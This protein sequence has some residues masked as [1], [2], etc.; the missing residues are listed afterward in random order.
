MTVIAASL[1][2]S[3]AAQDKELALPPLATAFLIWGLG[4]LFY[5]VG[6]Y[7]R[8]AP[9]VITRELMSEFG[10]GA[11]ALGNLAA[12]YYY[13]YVAIQVPAGVLADAWG[14][15]RLLTVGAVIATIGT[16]LFVL[17]PNYAGAGFGRLLIGGG[18]GVAFV[19][20]IKLAS[21]WFPATRFAMLSG[22]LVGC[23]ILGAVSAGVPL[24]WL[25][26]LFSWRPVLFSLGVIT[27]FI[28][29]AIWWLVRDDP[30]E[31]GFASFAQKLT[32]QRV[33]V[34]TGIKQSLAN[35]NVLV[36]VLVSGAMTGP[37]LAFGGLWGVP[38]LTT[39]Y[40]LTTSQA[41][42]VTS[43]MLICWALSGPLLG[44]L[45][46][47]V[48]RRRAPY[49]LGMLLTAFGWACVILL[50]G[51]PLPLLVALLGVIGCASAA[52][53]VG[54]A[55]VKESAPA[56]LAGTATGIANVGNML[57]SM[58]MPPLVG[59]SLDR[60]WN[61]AYANGVKVYDFDAYRSG[62]ALMLAWVLCALIIVA[63]VRETHGRQQ[64]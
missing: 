34:L 33:P 57:G 26:D 27:G 62:F 50:P 61:G 8:V 32:R 43:F 39:H 40:G 37:M 16:M 10:L 25:V 31:R 54:F 41:S 36:V 47:R 56:A 55:I 3:S 23:G 12:L 13:G 49:V 11:A 21:H 30:N 9:A 4:A 7:H 18:A 17:S 48:R 2:A 59:W 64:S 46:D 45:S 53:M 38:F 24:R 42:M 22:L 63:F 28:A 58:I 29:M 5:L 60:H 20:A 6:F 15:R 44:A 14:P 52:A 1:V 35:R 51:L 19:A